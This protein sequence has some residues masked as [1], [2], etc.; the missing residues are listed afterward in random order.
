MSDALQHKK[1]AISNRPRSRM[2]FEAILNKRTDSNFRFNKH[3]ILIPASILVYALIP[4][5]MIYVC[6]KT[7]FRKFRGLKRR[8]ISEI[9]SEAENNIFYKGPATKALEPELACILATLNLYRDLPRVTIRTGR[10]ITE[11]CTIQSS[12]VREAGAGVRV[13]RT[14]AVAPGRWGC[15]A[16]SAT[17]ATGSQNLVS[18]ARTLCKYVCGACT[19]C[20]V[21]CAGQK[22][23]RAAT[24]SNI[25]PAMKE[26]KKYIICLEGKTVDKRAIV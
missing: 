9:N 23:Q 5:P 13:G 16:L 21:V 14:Y 3:Q 4:I 18:G 11:L 6:T 20:E 26:T 12:T 25:V 2:P 22:E 17:R 1:E 24:Y 10:G 15:Q 19:K 8:L 7:L